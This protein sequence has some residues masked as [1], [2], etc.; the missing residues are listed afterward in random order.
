VSNSSCIYIAPYQ[1]TVT[2]TTGSSF[3]TRTY[4]SYGHETCPYDSNCSSY[5]NT[6]TYYANNRSLSV[7]T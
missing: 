2:I 1:D 7:G 4:S 3:G 5:S 6:W